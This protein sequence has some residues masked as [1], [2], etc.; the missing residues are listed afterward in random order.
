MC[1]QFPCLLR[2]TKRN[3]SEEKIMDVKKKSNGDSKDYIW[4]CRMAAAMPLVV[5]ATSAKWNE[6]HHYHNKQEGGMFFYGVP[7]LSWK[8]YRLFW[9]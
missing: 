4:F 5:T 6:L 1:G 7:A 8:C 9:E 3:S 2:I